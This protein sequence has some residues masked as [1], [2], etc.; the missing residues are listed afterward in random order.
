MEAAEHVKCTGLTVKVE[1]VVG[2]GVLRVPG[3]VVLGSKGT[4]EQGSVATLVS[5]QLPS[6]IKGS[7]L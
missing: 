7:G 6:Q 5:R 2:G 3:S 1:K 4:K